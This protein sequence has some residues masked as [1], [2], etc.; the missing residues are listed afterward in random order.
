MTRLLPPLGLVALLALPAGLAADDAIA[1]P[2]TPVRSLAE[3]SHL[4]W[5]CLDFRA[6]T[7]LATATTHVCVNPARE[8]D[9]RASWRHRAQPALPEP[10][11]DLYRMTLD[12][13]VA[14]RQNQEETFFDPRSMALV[15]RTRVRLGAKGN[16]KSYRLTD[17]ALHVLRASPASDTEIAGPEEAWTRHE[18]SEFPLPPSTCQVLSEASLLLYLAS[19][20]D[21]SAGPPPDLCFFSGK[22]WNRVLAISEGEKAVESRW[23]EGGVERQASRAWVIRLEAQA[24]EGEEKV[25]LLGLSGDLSLW[26]DPVSRRPLMIQ[27]QVPWLGLI[28]VQLV[29]AVPLAQ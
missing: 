4:T 6:E 28:S 21:W 2:N 7:L 17:R 22:N 27:G 15:Q 19:T 5:Q 18:Q 8:A 13:S 14:G 23:L 25:E 1:P 10:I 29:G 9:L 12:T 16:R 26:V 11:G 24:L 20:H 3:P